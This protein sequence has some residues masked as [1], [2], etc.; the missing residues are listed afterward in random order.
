MDL[1]EEQFTKAAELEP[2]SYDNNHNL[3][4]AFAHS[5]KVVEGD[6]ALL[7]AQD[8]QEAD[9]LRQARLVKLDPLPEWRSVTSF[10]ESRS[11]W[12]E[13][14]RWAKDAEGLTGDKLIEFVD[15]DLFK[16]LKELPRSGKADRSLC[17]SARR[18]GES[19]ASS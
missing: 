11:N 5:G 2:G 8:A 18:C 15:G 16:T 6:D 7:R 12:S 14:Q 1:A 13:F 4:A 9:W 10:A 3:G 19:A 17:F